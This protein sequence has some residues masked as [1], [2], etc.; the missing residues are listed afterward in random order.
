MFSS[1]HDK[2]VILLVATKHTPWFISPTEDCLAGYF[3]PL[4][5]RPQGVE[6]NGET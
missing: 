5:W 3:A 4:L 6:A 1:G 2:S